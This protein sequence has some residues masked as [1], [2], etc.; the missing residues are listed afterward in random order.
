MARFEQVRE[1]AGRLTGTDTIRLAVTGLSRAGKTVFITSLIHNLLA[2]ARGHRGALPRLHD[3]GIGE[4]LTGARVVPPAIEAI[5]RFPYA[6]NLAAR[7]AAEPA[8]PPTTAD[9][10]QISL[11]LTVQR[12]PAGLGR[13]LGAR[14]ITLEILDYP[15]EW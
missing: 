8:W 13:L 9:I 6:E 1:L 3:A 5:A 14:K 2:V 7:A 11:E 15:G 12:D 10:A 4:R